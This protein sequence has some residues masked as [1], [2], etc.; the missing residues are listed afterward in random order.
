MSEVMRQNDDGSWS[1]AKPIPLSWGVRLE[2][3]W[4]KKFG[5]RRG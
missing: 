5:R 4:L 3:W 1:P 2:L